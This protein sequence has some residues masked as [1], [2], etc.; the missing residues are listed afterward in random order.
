LGFTLTCS[1][2]DLEHLD[3][4]LTRTGL[5]EGNIGDDVLPWRVVDDCLHV[6]TSFGCDERNPTDGSMSP[7]SY[8]FL[9]SLTPMSY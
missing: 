9:R 3:A 4:H 2:S 8:D 1:S 6:T 5:D 7:V